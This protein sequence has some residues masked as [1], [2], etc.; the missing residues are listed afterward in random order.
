MQIVILCGG[1]GTRLADVNGNL[2]K[3]LTKF[4]NKTY[5]EILFEYL[6]NFD[7]IE[8]IILLTGYG[9]DQVQNKLDS[10]TTN[11]KIK[12]SKDLTL[13]G[14]GTKSIID[15]AKLNLLQDDFVLIFGDSLPQFNIQE[16][17]KLFKDNKMDMLMTYISKNLVNEVSR[18]NLEG[19]RITYS[20]KLNPHER[21][22]FVD[23]GVTFFSLPV[24]K[25]YINNLDLD[26]KSFIELIT[27]HCHVYG[28]EV[29]QPYLEFGNLDSY[30]I[31]HKKFEDLARKKF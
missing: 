16:T 21:F 24:L 4:N 30:K 9:H 11:F 2:P 20:S 6:E 15:A 12:I 26:L 8:E 22:N 5:L 31:A 25:K 17:Y 14:G 3:I 19:N 1:K 10:I 13:G 18:I 28:Y 27:E 29:N 23:Y 7:Q